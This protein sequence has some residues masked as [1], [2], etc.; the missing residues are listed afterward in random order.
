MT[1]DLRGVQPVMILEMGDDLAAVFNRAIRRLGYRV[2]RRV[3]R[4]RIAGAPEHRMTIRA[5]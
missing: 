3:H 2:G 1:A 4:R 5:A